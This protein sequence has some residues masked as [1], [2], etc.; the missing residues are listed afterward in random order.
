LTSKKTSLLQAH[1]TTFP[2][3]LLV[4]IQH[5]LPEVPYHLFNTVVIE[6]IVVG[7]YQSTS[8]LSGFFLQEESVDEDTDP[9][10]SEGIFVY[11][12]TMDVS[13]GDVVRVQGDVKE[14]YGLTEITDV[15]EM[16]ICPSVGESIAV[17]NVNLPFTS[18][19]D[20]EKFEGMKVAFP[21]KLFTTEHYNLG[22]YGQ[23]WMSATDRLWQPT[24]VTTPGASANAQQTAN[25]LNRV[26]IDDASNLQNPDPIVFPPPELTYTNTLR[27]GDTVTGMQGVVSYGY[28]NYMIY[29]TSY[30][31]A[32]D[33][34]RSATPPDVGGSFKVASFNVHNYFNGDGQG[35]GFPTA[36][37]ADTLEEFNRQR[38]KI[39][40]AILSLHADVIGLMEI[41]NDGYDQY[42]AIQDLVNGLNATAPIGTT[43]AFID[44]AVSAIGTDEIAVGIIYRVETADP[45]GSA[46]IL[47][48]TFDTNYHD[49]YNRPAL[50]QTFEQITTNERFTVVVNHLKSKGSD[51]EAI[52]DY[53]QH[54]GQGNCNATRSSAATVETAW[55]ATDPTS[56]GDPDF[57]VIGDLNAY[58]NEDPIAAFATNTTTLPTISGAGVWH[59]NADEP[60][61]LDYNTEYKSTHQQT[62]L[63]SS[64]SF[65][66]SDHDPVIV[67]LFD[68]DFS[69]L[70]ESYGIAYHTGGGV[71]RIGSGWDALNDTSNG[72]DNATDDGVSIITTPWIPNQEA[73]VAITTNAP[74]YL[75]AWFDW[76]N[77]GTFD[78]G[79]LTISQAITEAGVH[80]ITFT[81]GAAFDPASNQFYNARFRFYADEPTTLSPTGEGE[82]GEVEDYHWEFG[83]T[84][85]TLKT[86]SAGSGVPLAVVIGGVALLFFLAGVAWLTL[87]K[88][89]A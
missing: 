16:Q 1:G 53:D 29:P 46:A 39:I 82:G 4:T 3:I 6:G 62:S 48:N 64:G 73:S 68:Y 58:R 78:A 33:N 85:I 17:P 24:H 63:Y 45:V 35:G 89:R 50:A 74:G 44:P 19:T 56:S 9:D 21:Q 13:P 66:S 15:T 23:F 83:P 25:D 7:D 81:I 77:N 61:A 36:R 84:A 57:L 51:C 71:L 27:S 22:L 10:T 18:S 5:L 49:D 80:T 76:D 67:G 52:G 47:D 87:S 75:A 88:R 40:N 28:G 86:L 38:D 31:I 54:D 34:P 65:R 20:M 26:L 11:T 70:P 69:D 72:A 43:Y 37:G 12:T 55:L 14:Q 79:E 8:Q 41:E 2:V 32:E 42:S 60:R 59:I 30:T